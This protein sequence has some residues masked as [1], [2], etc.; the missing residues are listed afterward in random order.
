MKKENLTEKQISIWIV[1]VSLFLAGLMI[2]NAS[3]FDYDNKETVN[4]MLIAIW[5]LPYSYLNGKTEKC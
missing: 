5:F 3:L 1:V 4:F 2:L